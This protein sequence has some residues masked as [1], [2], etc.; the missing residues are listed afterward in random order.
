MT[1]QMSDSFI[2]KR[3]KYV[4]VDVEENKQLIDCAEF[5]LSENPFALCSACWRGYTAE[6]RVTKGKLY[7]ERYEWD[8]EKHEDIVSESLF[9][10]YTGSCVVARTVNKNRWLNS[11]FLECYLNFDEA[12]ELHFTNGILDEVHD[13]AEAIKMANEGKMLADGANYDFIARYFL[14]YKYDYRT[15]KW[16]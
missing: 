3:K 5:Q 15:Y 10:N 11:D 14:K 13:L 8:N 1:V 4:L 6:Y 16:R 2:Y 7:G 9:L 12:L